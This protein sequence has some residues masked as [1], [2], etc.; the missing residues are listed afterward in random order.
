VVAGLDLAKRRRRAPPLSALT[1]HPLADGFDF[2]QHPA[3]PW[4]LPQPSSVVRKRTG[5]GRFFVPLI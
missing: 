4:R 5:F 1:R 3:A 2:R